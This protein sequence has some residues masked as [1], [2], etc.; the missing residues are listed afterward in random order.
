MA[1]RNGYSIRIVATAIWTVVRGNTGG[2][3]KGSTGHTTVVITRFTR[4]IILTLV[5]CYTRY[6]TCI[7]MCTL[8]T[9]ARTPI[10]RQNSIA[11]RSIWVLG[12]QIRIRTATGCSPRRYNAVRLGKLRTVSSCEIRIKFHI[13]CHVRSRTTTAFL[14][15]D[16]I[17]RR[18]AGRGCRS[19]ARY[20]IPI[21]AVCC[22]RTCSRRGCR[23]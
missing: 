18:R 6:S 23:I 7:N 17:S 10:R 9:I 15:R 13:L 11:N 1:G 2:T 8:G 14:I 22:I 5:S 19:I 12:I 16:G 20:C 3:F 21:I 4:V